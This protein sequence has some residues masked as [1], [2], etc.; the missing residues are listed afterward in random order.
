MSCVYYQS[1]PKNGH[2]VLTTQVTSWQLACRRAPDCKSV[3][4][5]LRVQKM[6]RNVN[7]SWLLDVPL[8]SWRPADLFTLG[9]FAYTFRL[10]GKLVTKELITCVRSVVPER[11]CGALLVSLSVLHSHWLFCGVPT[12]QRLSCVLCGSQPPL[13]M[14]AMVVEGVFILSGG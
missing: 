13:Q 7:S 9:V 1:F 4:F 2:D 8:V 14:S 12:E 11:V 6:L 5:V 10:H 3:T